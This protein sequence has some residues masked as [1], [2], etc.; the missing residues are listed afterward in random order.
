M[1][2]GSVP[3]SM[4]SAMPRTIELDGMSV[5]DGAFP[6]GLS[7]PSHYHDGASVFVIIG[8]SLVETFR[9]RSCECASS[10]VLAKPAG[11]RHRD[12]MGPLGARAVAVTPMGERAEQFGSYLPD[13]VTHFGD[14]RVGALAR[15]IAGELR[16]GDDLAPMAVEGLALELLSEVA[17][18]VSRVREH[19][20][21]PAWL[22]LVDEYLHDRFRE[23]FRVADVAAAAGVHPVHLARVFRT[24]RRL[25][26]GVYVR[27]LRLEWAADR[28]SDG[29][30]TL[31][32]IALQ[33]GFSD[34]SH[35]TRAFKLHTG[36]TPR[37]YQRL[38]AR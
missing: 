21:E 28:L 15:R 24:H 23:R 26:M 38:A 32:E 22:T 30:P 16:G 34:Q 8:G 35:F 12:R 11:E 1:E 13:G 36:Y 10:T 18:R 31:S 27:R 19:G 3:L 4:F 17:R 25:T 14:H 6:A 9:A 33:S 5:F 7:L 37:Q 2:Q 20:A 29:A